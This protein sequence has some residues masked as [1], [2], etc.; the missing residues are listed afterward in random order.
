MPGCPA[1]A[2]A[3]NEYVMSDPG[4]AETEGPQGTANAPAARERSDAEDAIVLTTD[5]EAQTADSVVRPDNS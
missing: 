5:P 3:R 1:D 4:L 2:D